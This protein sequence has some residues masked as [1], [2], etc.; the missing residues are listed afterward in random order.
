MIRC[1]HSQRGRVL[2]PHHFTWKELPCLP[3]SPPIHRDR[4]RRTDG[5]AVRHHP[6]ARRT[7]TRDRRASGHWVGDRRRR[8]PLRR[9]RRGRAR[10]RVAAARDPE[11]GMLDE[12]T[13]R[14]DVTGA[15]GTF[16]VR[17]HHRGFLVQVCDADPDR[18]ATCVQPQESTTSSGTSDPTARTTAGSS[19]PTCTTPRRPTWMSAA[20]RCSRPPGSRATWRA[21]ASR[22]IEVMRL[23]TP[24]RST[25]RPT[26]R[27]LHDQG[28]GARQLLPAGRWLRHRCT[29]SPS[30]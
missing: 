13:D 18:T 21:P 8:R 20:S 19:T 2:P 6:P 28:P 24:S 29:G 14:W 25:A 30:R 5:R 23:T 15:D 12:T 3:D 1:N 7:S 26:R 27:R 10:Q 9:S 4:C 17:Q 11:F 22:R 16:R